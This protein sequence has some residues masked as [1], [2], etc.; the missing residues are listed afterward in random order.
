MIKPIGA[1]VLL[2][3]ADMPE[4]LTFEDYVSFG[5]Y[6]EDEETDGQGISD[7]VVFAYL[8]DLQ[9]L[10]RCRTSNDFDWRLVEILQVHYE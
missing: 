5:T 1:T 9:H 7:L 6:D 8:D 2:R 3:W 10:E 4:D